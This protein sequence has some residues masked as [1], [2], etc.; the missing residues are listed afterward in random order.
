MSVKTYSAKH[1]YHDVQEK[2]LVGEASSLQLEFG[3]LYADAYDIG[4][5]LYNPASDLT[6]YWYLADTCV[7]N[8][9]TQYWDLK[10][11]IP[12]NDLQRRYT[13]RIFN[14]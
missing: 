9:D 4:L 11:C 2:L 12:K 3:R 5:A 13:M 6:S 8:G 1:F 14:D 7:N 10:P